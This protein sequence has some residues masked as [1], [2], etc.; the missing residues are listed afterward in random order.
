MHLHR[1]L[2][3]TLIIIAA[4][5]LA[6]GD[7]E[8]KP[9]QPTINLLT[10]NPETGKPTLTWSKP[11]YNPL[12]PNPTGYIIYKPH[13]GGGWMKIDSVNAETYTYTD[14]NNSGLDKSIKYVIASKGPTEPSPLTPPHGSIYV[15]A[16]YDSCSNKINIAWNHYLGWGN[17]IDK[18]NLYIGE[19]ENW[20]EFTLTDTTKGIQ[21][22]AYYGVLPNSD[23]Y[24][25]V[26]A[27][28]REEELYSKSNL[29][30]INTRIA[31][32]P[33]YMYVDSLIAKD[34]QNEI[35]FTIDPETEFNRFK[36][37]RWESSDSTKSIFTAKTIFEFTDPS[38]IYLTDT[39]DSWA[40]RSRPFYYKIDAYDGCNSIKKVS[41]LSNTIIIRAR[42]AGNKST[43]SWEKFYSAQQNTI[44]YDLYR[45]AYREGSS[46]PELIY[47][48]E[49]PNKTE[50]IDDLSIF[51]G[52]GYLPYFCYYIEANEILGEGQTPRVSRS[53]TIC[54]QIDPDV[55]MPNAIDPLSTIVSP[56]GV[57]RNVL[58]PTISFESTYILTIY[59]RGGSVVFEGNGEGWDGRLPNGQL[60]PEGTYV[61]RLEVISDSKKI[62]SKTG[63]VT[64]MYGPK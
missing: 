50:Y 26:E 47:K 56:E 43:I 8:P 57:P 7:P 24:I 11:K 42:S 30:H 9:L 22:I 61:Y 1:I 51:E 45:M 15:T 4:S 39:S 25:Y 10:L 62:K 6:Q 52:Q 37:I 27:K 17:Q 58:A 46:I 49:N 53:R 14:N 18:Y 33:Q 12:N 35:H 13:E 38:T 55:T 63:T 19:N 41:N 60:A 23:Y 16:E 5:C 2:T 28:K 32:A 48:S 36:L 44:R 20:Q 21:N 40:A 3:F 31:K 64:V 59:S 29:A 34:H 54:T